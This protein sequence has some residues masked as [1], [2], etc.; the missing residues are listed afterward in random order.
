MPN[1]PGHRPSTLRHHLARFREMEPRWIADAAARYANPSEV[2]PEDRRRLVEQFLASRVVFYPGSGSD[3]G[4]VAAFNSASAAHC[5]AYADYL[6]EKRSILGDL[7]GN[8]TDY[9]SAFRGYRTAARI[10]LSEDD[11]PVWPP[12]I[13]LHKKPW[14]NTATPYTFI[15]I[16]K[17]QDQ[18]GFD[19][20]HGARYFAFMFLG[21]DGFPTYQA[22]FCRN[23]GV[24]GPF[25]VVLQD[26]GFGGNYSNFGA[27]GLLEEVARKHGVFPQ[28]ALIG[29]GTEAWPGYQRCVNDWEMMGMHGSHRYLWQ[30]AD[31]NAGRAEQR[32]R[33]G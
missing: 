11:F 22:L 29:D 5:F 20:R 23:I 17:R 21:M 25:C 26:H 9:S 8:G 30:L 13:R 12:S 2:R 3:G 19:D 24:P 28:L 14:V 32:R 18:D 4:P 7:D 27:G 33:W 31:G 15:N 1:L 6:V 10:E 16:L